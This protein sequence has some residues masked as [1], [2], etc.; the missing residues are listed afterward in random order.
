[1]SRRN[2]IRVFSFRYQ[3]TAAAMIREKQCNC[4]EEQDWNLQGGG[5]L[6]LRN[7]Q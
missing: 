1:M 6:A 4:D 7:R 2:Q 3:K 5:H